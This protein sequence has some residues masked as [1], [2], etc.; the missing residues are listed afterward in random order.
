VAQG[1]VVAG[2]GLL[3]M[4]EGRCATFLAQGTGFDLCEGE[5]RTL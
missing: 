1:D 5:Q 4:S 3:R 2:L